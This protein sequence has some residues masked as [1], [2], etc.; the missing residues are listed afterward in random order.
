MITSN[1]RSNCSYI[2]FLIPLI[3]LQFHDVVG[4]SS[5]MDFLP[6]ADVRT[7]PI[8]TQTCLSD[9]VHTFYG[10][11][12]VRPETTYEDLRATTGN[13]GNV[14]EN[15]SLY[16]HPTVYS[17]DYDTSTYKK[18]SIYFASAYYIW[19]TGKAKAFPNGFKMIA[20]FGDDN[21][22]ANAECVGP[23]ECEKSNCST[24]NDFFP[25]TACE[26]LEVSMAFPTCWDGVNIDSSDHRSHVSYDIDNGE[27][28]GGMNVIRVDSMWHLSSL[29]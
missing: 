29:F 11:A 3:S 26:E 22:R 28:G 20:G 23:S 21:T 7:D 5:K 17:Y 15:K 18:D 9:H 14:E 10:A 4:T 12:A 27:F 1:R 2:Y 13:S 19:E 16:W 24:N 6:L 25:T 8:V